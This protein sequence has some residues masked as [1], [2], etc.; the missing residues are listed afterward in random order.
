MAPEERVTDQD[1]ESIDDQ[2][3]SEKH[4]QILVA[5]AGGKLH[6]AVERVA[7]VLNHFP[8]ARDS[9]ITLQLKY[10]QYFHNY[11][12]GS[13]SPEDLYELPR[14]TSLSRARAYIQNNHKLFQASPDVRK[15]RGTLEDEERE[16][17]LNQRPSWPVFAV[18]ADES[19]K[20]ADHL[21]VGSIW[22]LHGYETFRVNQE[23]RKWREENSFKEE[24][25]FKDINK[26]NVRSYI[27]IAEM[28]L[29]NSNVISFKAIS[30]EKSGTKDV[31][32]ALSELY[33]HLLI[34][35]IEHEHKTG[36][37]PLPRS[38][39]VWKDAESPGPDKLLLA[40]I[41]DKLKQASKTR[42]EEKLYVDHLEAVNSKALDL[43]QLADL[44]TSSINRV[45]NVQSEQ[46]GPKDEFAKHF[47]GG[48]G[49][50]HGITKE[51]TL[52]DMTVHISL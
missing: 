12:G 19:G 28:L 33:Y 51:E 46:E 49:M 14:L 21:I 43:I 44:F 35:G 10:W 15:R 2:R 27:E 16:R 22:F 3:S 39:Q 6:T 1:K 20:T 45:L 18:Y 38:I 47:L 5:A 41:D 11:G 37:A 24:F 7:W 13:I 26:S 34:K 48:L 23:V 8:E 32:K 31:Q 4:G 9:D 25:H 52:G 17:A 40:D 30:L 50:P 29:A 42:F 36:R